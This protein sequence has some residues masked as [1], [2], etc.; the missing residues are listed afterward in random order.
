MSDEIMRCP[1]CVLGGEFRPMY[2]Q[3]KEWF[4]CLSCVHMAAPN[5]PHMKCPCTRCLEAKLMANRCRNAD[6]PRNG[7]NDLLAGL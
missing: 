1:Y 6:E 3:S 7:P 4:V 5:N 2:Q